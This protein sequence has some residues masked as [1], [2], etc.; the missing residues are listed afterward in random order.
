MTRVT[1]EVEGRR[2]R[3]RGARALRGWALARRQLL[4]TTVGRA[5]PRGTFP[6]IKVKLLRP[7]SLQV[8]ESVRLE[9]PPP[10]VPNGHGAVVDHGQ[11]R[12]R[13]LPLH[14]LKGQADSDADLLLQE[15]EAGGL[16]LRAA[17]ALG[18]STHPGLPGTSRGLALNVPLP[19]ASGAWLLSDRRV[20]YPRRRLPLRRH[21]R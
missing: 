3:G 12:G 9:L 16:S 20:S 6:V 8:L 10:V 21:P 19:R 14:G 13:F 7:V 17:L 5:A 11:S 2:R 1:E 4:G 18:G 15:E